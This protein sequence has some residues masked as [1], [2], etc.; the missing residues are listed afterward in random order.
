ME[1]YQL[2]Q[3]IDKPTRITNHTV[4]YFYYGLFP[5]GEVSTKQQAERLFHRENGPDVSISTSTTTRIF[6]FLVLT[7][8][9]ASSGVV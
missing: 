6:L 2:S 1:I 3:L 7:L 5:G 8:A 9:F 4:G